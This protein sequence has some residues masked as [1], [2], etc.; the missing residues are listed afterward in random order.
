M[1]TFPTF[2]QSKDMH[3]RVV[4]RRLKFPFLWAIYG[5]LRNTF[6]ELKRCMIDYCHEGKPPLNSLTK[7][8]K[9]L[10]ISLKQTFPLLDEAISHHGNSLMH[11]F[12]SENVF[13]KHS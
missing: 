9:W 6:S 2:P 7:Q 1:G 10:K 3:S 13:L 8:W 5:C 11:G 4:T 12:S